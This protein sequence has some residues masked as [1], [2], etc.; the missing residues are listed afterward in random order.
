MLS[1]FD[2]LSESDKRLVDSE[3]LLSFSRQEG[4]ARA[5]NALAT[6]MP[7]AADVPAAR[8]LYAGYITNRL[9]PPSNGARNQVVQEAMDLLANI[10]EGRVTLDPEVVAALT[11]L[12]RRSSWVEQWIMQ[13][14]PQQGVAQLSK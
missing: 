6:T 4:I 9:T 1:T 10:D 7:T 8:A 14:A 11:H 2:M 12:P 5:M 3:V 13:K